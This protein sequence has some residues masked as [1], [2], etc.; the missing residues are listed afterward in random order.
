MYRW[1]ET[2]P[3]ILSSGHSFERLLGLFS[4]RM[5]MSDDA[6]RAHGIVWILFY[7]DYI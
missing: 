7:F 2:G 4:N 6:K 5:G 1:N 3:L